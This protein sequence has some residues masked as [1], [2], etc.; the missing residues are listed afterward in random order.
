[1]T[2]AMTLIKMYFVG[3]LRALTQDVSRRLFEQV[4]FSFR[5]GPCLPLFPHLALQDVS[6]TAQMHLLYTRFTTVAGQ[7][8]PLLGEF[9][10]RARTHPEELGALLS[11]CHAAYFAARKSLLVARLTEQIRGLDPTRT[12]LVELV[13][14]SSA[15]CSQES[16][17]HTTPHER[18]S[19]QTRSG[20][21]YL[22][23]LCTEE[24]DLY[25]AFFSSGKEG[26]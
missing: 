1:M 10:R 8:A 14:F 9:E 21:S 22:K 11:E 23:Q 7:L 24:F 25:R 18:V 4:S 13:R 26:L 15:S 6:D 12:E 19:L 16:N 5:T 3:S 17:R 20:C 2:R